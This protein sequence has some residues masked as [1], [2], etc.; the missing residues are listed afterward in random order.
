M[1]LCSIY[2]LKLKKNLLCLLG[3]VFH[4][5]QFT[6]RKQALLRNKGCLGECKTQ[7]E[8]HVIFEMTH[9]IF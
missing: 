7:K 3:I 2:I 6:V 9:D 4:A 1:P 8:K 5:L